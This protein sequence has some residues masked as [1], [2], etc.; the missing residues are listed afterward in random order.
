MTAMFDLFILKALN[1]VYNNDFWTVHN[2]FPS[3]HNLTELDLGVEVYCAETLLFE[4]LEHSPIL[5]NSIFPWV[6]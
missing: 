5:Q 1:A 6:R 2:G 3:F 4:F